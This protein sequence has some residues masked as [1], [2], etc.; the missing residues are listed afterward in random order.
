MRSRIRENVDVSR[1]SEVSR[2]QPRARNRTSRLRPGITFCRSVALVD[3]DSLR[4]RT[5]VN[6]DHGH[7]FVCFVDEV[8]HASARFEGSGVTTHRIAAT[9]DDARGGAAD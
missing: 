7:G 1:W 6:P 5:G 3:D 9:F 4:L 8:V 2:L